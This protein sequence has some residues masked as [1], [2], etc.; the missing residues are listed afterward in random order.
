MK[1]GPREGIGVAVCLF[2]RNVRSPVKGERKNRETALSQRLAERSRLALSAEGF[3]AA[4]VV[5]KVRGINKNCGSALSTC[6]IARRSYE[7]ATT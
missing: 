7:L 5:A 2:T 6:V 1:G 3:T 4:T